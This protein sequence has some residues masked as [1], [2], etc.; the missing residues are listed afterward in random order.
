MRVCPFLPVGAQP[1]AAPNKRCTGCMWGDMKGWFRSFM[2]LL[3]LKVYFSLFFF[4]V[5]RVYC[6]L[7]IYPYDCCIIPISVID[8]DIFLINALRIWRL[9]LSDV[10]FFSKFVF[11]FWFYPPSPNV[12][13]VFSWCVNQ[14][15]F[16]IMSWFVLM[17]CISEKEDSGTRLKENYGGNL[18][19]FCLCDPALHLC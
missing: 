11:Q 18:S 12:T 6:Y 9:W 14:K 8:M 13:L 16:N 2:E 19:F 15:L 3:N 4:L 1:A 10:H 17:F 5:Q 7:W